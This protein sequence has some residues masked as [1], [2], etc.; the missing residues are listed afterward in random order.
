M[1]DSLESFKPFCLVSAGA[2]TGSWTRFHLSKCV[3]A[4]LFSEYLGTFTVNIL[5]TFLLGLLLAFNPYL[6]HGSF[7]QNSSLFLFICVGFL[8]SLSTF[9]TF[10]IDLLKILLQKQWKRSFYLAMFS[11]IGGLLA[12]ALGLSFG[13]F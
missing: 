7:N 5:A 13:D 4:I 2:I 10:I 11:V 12:A 1:F 3:G 6:V 8:A 9:S